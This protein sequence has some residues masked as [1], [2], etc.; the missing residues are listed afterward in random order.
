MHR[1][2]TTQ[3][4]SS[5][6]A[7]D[8]RAAIIFS[9]ARDTLELQLGGGRCCVLALAGVSHAAPGQKVDVPPSVRLSVHRGLIDT[10]GRQNVSA[11]AAKKLKREAAIVEMTER[12]ATGQA[13]SIRAA[14]FQAAESTG[15]GGTLEFKANYLA[16]EYRKRFCVPASAFFPKS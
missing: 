3:L 1:I 14:S 5:A 9:P 16:K 13:R 12:L 8:L 4:S 15:N 10:S 6:T 11:R 2:S 7:E